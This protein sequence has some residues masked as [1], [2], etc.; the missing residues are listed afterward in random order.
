MNLNDLIIELLEL[1]KQGYGD[2]KLGFDYQKEI[3]SV[4]YEEREDI[5]LFY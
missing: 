2:K 4:E 5:I 3:N 1:Q